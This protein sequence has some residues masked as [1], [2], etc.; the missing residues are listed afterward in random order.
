MARVHAVSHDRTAALDVNVVVIDLIRIIGIR[1]IVVIVRSDEAGARD[2]DPTVVEAVME[3]RSEMR[4]GHS[5]VT[6]GHATAHRRG[7]KCGGKDVVMIGAPLAL[8]VAY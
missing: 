6:I 1:V 7:M 3:A 8:T 4:P 5:G 2:K